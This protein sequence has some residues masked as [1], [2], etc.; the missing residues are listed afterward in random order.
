MSDMKAKS[1]SKKAKISKIKSI[2]PT[3]INQGPKPIDER[4]YP[5]P[6]SEICSEHEGKF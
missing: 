2:N 3:L 6:R 5:I 4:G 1:K